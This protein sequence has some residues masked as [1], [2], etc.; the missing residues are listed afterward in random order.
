MQHRCIRWLS[1][2]PTPWHRCKF[3]HQIEIKRRPSQD[4]QVTGWTDGVKL[5]ISALD[6]LCSRDDVKHAA[7]KSSAPV[8]PVVHRSIA[9]VQWRQQVEKSATA[10]WRSSVTNLTDALSIG[11]TDGPWSRC[12]S[13]REANGYFRAQSDRKNRCPMHLHANNSKSWR[14][15]PSKVAQVMRKKRM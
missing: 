4:S 9:S 2:V 13:V 15:W 8:E 7:A 5:G 6:V 1:E 14:R 12:D 11:L 10:I 3:E